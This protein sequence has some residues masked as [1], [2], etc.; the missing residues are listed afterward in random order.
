MSG[1]CGFFRNSEG[2]TLLEILVATVVLSVG[3]V[4]IVGVTTSVMS[5]VTLSGR[6]TTAT[7]LAQEK[8]E[9]M[10]RLGY[11]GMSDT[12]GTDTEDY[13]TIRHYPLFK[14]I[15]FT[16]VSHAADG[17][18]MVTVTV[19]WDGDRHRVVLKTLVGE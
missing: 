15:V 1:F 17:L 3:F 6:M 2:F 7:T 5:G 13:Y 16:S 4:G 19:W 14:R 10:R 8:M 12:D 11:A 18:K 9:E